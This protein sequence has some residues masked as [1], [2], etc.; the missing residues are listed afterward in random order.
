MI[1]VPLPTENCFIKIQIRDCFDDN[2]VVVTSINPTT[3]S[4]DN[5]T[6]FTV[7]RPVEILSTATPSGNGLTTDIGEKSLPP[8]TCLC[9]MKTL[10][11]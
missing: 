2:E 9:V 7:D 6:T 1:D 3:A 10:P 5:Q 4:V 11:L 8:L